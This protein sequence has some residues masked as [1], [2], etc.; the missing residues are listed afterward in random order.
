MSSDLLKTLSMAVEHELGNKQIDNN[1]RDSLAQ[2]V[3]QLA[4][5]EQQGLPAFTVAPPPGDCPACGQALP[6]K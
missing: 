5:L 4:E 1:T 2:M 3:T 6:K